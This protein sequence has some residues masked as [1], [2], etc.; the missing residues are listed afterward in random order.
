MFR[1]GPGAPGG[2]PPAAPQSPYGASGQ[3]AAPQ[4]AGYGNTGYDDTGY[5]PGGHDATGYGNPGNPGNPAYGATGHR[6]PADSPRGRPSR[7]GDTGRSRTPLI[8]GGV[9]VI[10]VIAAVGV[11][12]SGAFGE[13]EQGDKAAAGITT[14][15][16]ASGKSTAKPTAATTPKATPK[17][18]KK[19]AADPTG[20]QAAA[21][22]KLL[23]AGAGSRQVVSRAV[24][25]IQSCSDPAAG[26]KELN[27]AAKQREQQIAGLA[28][29]KTD[30]LTR[31]SDLVTALRDAWKASAESDRQLAAWGNEMA[32]GGC[33]DKRPESTAHKRAAD[34][35]SGKATTAKSKAVALWNPI[36]STT[37]LKKRTA[38]E[39]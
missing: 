11:F 17:P 35:A 22:D 15:A 36:A 20:G 37:K 10:V 9:G 31:G 6:P 30:K 38:G 2:P 3:Y 18:T 33:R 21:V 28:P 23:K 16:P 4:G 12:A 39:I 7:I 24:Q 1:D 19:P 8:A 14:S 25:K 32:R 29:L 34:R 27:E 5:R 13:D 26:A